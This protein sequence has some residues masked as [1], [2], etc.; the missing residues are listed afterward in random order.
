MST[1]HFRR[2]AA[3]T[4]TAISG[5]QL[6]LD[7]NDLTTISLAGNTVT[8]IND[9]SVNANNTTSSTG[10]VTYAATGLSG[11]PAFSFNATGGFRG[12]TSITGTTLTAFTVATLNSGVNYNG[13]LLGLANATQT[14][15]QYAPTC[16]P[17][18]CVNGGPNIAAYRNNTY[19]S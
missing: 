14:D 15:Y 1:P 3:F 7:A 12:P 4:P 5:C 16:Q 18:F 19:M 10:T 17:F 13:R 2:S 6:W 8:Q 9:K 11:R